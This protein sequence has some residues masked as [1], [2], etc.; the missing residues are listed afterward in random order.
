MSNWTLITPDDLKAAGYGLVVD[1][2]QTISTGSVDPVLDA[3]AT[4]VARVRRAVSAANALDVNPAKVPMSLKG[5]VVR[6]AF[7]ALME[8]L[9][10]PLNEDQRTTRKED[11]SDLNRLTDHKLTVEAP[12]TADTTVVP[13][14]RG[15]WGGEN[16]VIGRMHPTPRPAVQFPANDNGYANPDGPADLGT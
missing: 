6:M 5:L 1:S 11:M 14:N 9:E 10:L 8:R 3:I 13:Q 16:K 2:A 15:T 4:A 12:D 7:F